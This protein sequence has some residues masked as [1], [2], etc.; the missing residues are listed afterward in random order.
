MDTQ[1]INEINDLFDKVEDSYRA[2]ARNNAKNH[3]L[4][5]VDL[6]EKELA[7]EWGE[8]NFGESNI[9]GVELRAIHETIIKIKEL[10]KELNNKFMLFVM[11]SGKNG[12]STLINAL[13]EQ[14]VAKESVNPET[15]KIDVFTSEDLTDGVILKFKDGTERHYTLK[16]AQN[17]LQLEDEKIKASKAYIRQ[18]LKQ[19]KNSG[20][21]LVALEEKQLELQKYYLYKSD[22]TEMI[23]SVKGK[24]I[25]KN[26]NLVDT[27]GLNQEID[28]IIISNVK[29]YYGK[30]DGIIWVLPGDRIASAG[31]RKEI[32]KVLEEY[33]NNNNII[34]VIN[35]LDNILAN[36]QTVEGVI[37]DAKKFYGDIFY[38]FI[39]IS[40]KQ[41]REA[42][43]ILS[44]SSKNS[45]TFLQAKKLLKESRFEHL[46]LHLNKTLFSNAL[47]IQ[48]QAKLKNTRLLYEDVKLK[49]EVLYKKI[50]D[51]N[52][53]R[54]DLKEDLDSELDEKI[55]Y[56][57][58][59][60]EILVQDEANRVGQI[61]ANY[62]EEL[63][64]LD[65]RKF[66][67]FVRDTIIEPEIVYKNLE[68]LI[69][70][71]EEDF[72]KFL[73]YKHL[74]NRFIEFENLYP[75]DSEVIFEVEFSD[76]DDFND[77]ATMFTGD[78]FWDSIG[79]SLAR[80]LTEK[81]SKRIRYKFESQLN[82][83]IK[84]IINS[85]HN[86]ISETS[87]IIHKNREDSFSILYGPSEIVPE[88]IERLS[89]LKNIEFSEFKDLSLSDLLFNT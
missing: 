86:N 68:S 63:W 71:C 18:E 7:Y 15:W 2:G 66:D 30:A 13:A 5:S 59:Q 82:N 40:A 49:T 9:T 55:E 39:P 80:V 83:M 11:G 89:V 27:P 32:E 10:A 61:A 52:N 48:I 57:K 29:E 58:D 50:K 44:I 19:A 36:G 73:T 77:I 16:E 75:I 25:L 81:K 42:Q 8:A 46:L 21:D 45:E 85:V 51:A 88:L 26:Y 35:R 47:E 4:K 38:D 17:Y 43:E 41:A 64:R 84:E 33:G 72:T 20:L 6:L 67:R 3:I 34:A 65:G 70:Q 60:F 23:T 54:I 37:S 87:S 31:D 62:E 56:W 76:F 28:G 1:L 79:R 53:K 14:L 22:V 74:A 69:S 12:K 24:G 78:G